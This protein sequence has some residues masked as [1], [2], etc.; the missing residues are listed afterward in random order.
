M[1]KSLEAISDIAGLEAKPGVS[2]AKSLLMERGAD[3]LASRLGRL[4]KGRNV[5]AHPD[6]ELLDAIKRLAVDMPG[7]I[8]RAD[9]LFPASSKHG[10]SACSSSSVGRITVA[11]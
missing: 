3:K 9:V 11:S 2:Q 8:V 4:S 1:E 6:H 5:N 10:P 7:G